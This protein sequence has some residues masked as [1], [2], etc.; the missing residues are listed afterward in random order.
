MTVN[1]TCAALAATST[2]P[3][4]SHRR[5]RVAVIVANGIT[6]DSRV[7]KTALAAARAGW[8]VTLIGRS[9]STMIERS[10]FGPV[11]V[12]RVP[13]SN[14]LAA[15]EAQR[16]VPRLQHGDVQF[17]A[18]EVRQARHDARS[19][20]RR[21][22]IAGL[23]T[24]AGTVPRT[25]LKAW[26]RLAEHGYTLG[27]RLR[28]AR[29][30]RETVPPGAP[31]GDWRR[32]MPMLL[33][34]D[35]AFGPV[36]ERLRPDLI[37]AND[38]TM[39]NTAASTAGVLRAAGH[40]V[41]WIYDA[42]EYVAGVDW[43]TRRMASGYPAVERELIHDADAV[44]TVSPEIAEVLAREHRLAV[45]PVV[46]RNT[47]VRSE[48]EDDAHPSVRSAAGV[49]AGV[50]LLVYSG[51]IHHERGIGV[52]VQALVDLP[53]HHLAVVAG[54]R[55]REL[56]HLLRTAES[57]GVIDRVHLAPYV[58]QHL[59]PRYLASADVGI[60]CSKRTIN[61]ELS[62]PTKFA[63]YVHAGLPVICSDVKTL[64]AW[65]RR[66]QVGEI[67]TADDPSSFADAVRRAWPRREQLSANIGQDLLTE[68]SW[69]HQA[70]ALTELYTAV[71]GVQPPPPEQPVSW[72]ARETLL[73]PPAPRGPRR[74]RKNW[75][76][77]GSSP[78]R[79]GLGPANFA[80]QMSAFAGAVC[81][82]R[83]DTTAEVFMYTSRK[84]GYPAD[85]RVRSQSLDRT[86]LQLEQVQRILPRYTHL[87]AD[88]FRPVFGPL[89]GTDIAGDLPALRQARISVGLV[90]HG[91]DVRHPQRH[92]E[93]VPDSL[94]RDAAP[95]TV[96][97]LTQ[98]AERH[99]QIVE[100]SGLPLFVTTPDLLLDV[101]QA[102]WAPLVVDTRWWSCD[103]PVLER[104]RPV[105]LHAPSRRWSKGTDRFLPTLEELDR[106]GLIELR[107]VED[108]KWRGMRA[109]VHDADIVVDQLVIGAYGAFAC[110]ALAA[111]KPVI[112]HLSPT[113]ADTIGEVPPIV[114]ATVDTLGTVLTELLDDRARTREIGQAGPGFVARHH[115]G[116][117]T[118][119]ALASFLETRA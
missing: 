17:T 76:P 9:T 111:G 44:V 115:D 83:D 10:R 97:Y 98:R 96:S 51:Y 13:V 90:A 49:A 66:H 18:D 77:L 19:R 31:V 32:D 41:R 85:V 106:R 72:E 108:L 53:E 1:L 23:D 70:G 81:A 52:A 84:F 71:T 15:L 110:E 69:E 89:N 60:I 95:G 26:N 105:V 114:N 24:P 78:V 39:L 55:N 103:R 7:Q 104:E 61:Y 86:A 25:A 47:P 22:L 73:P 38:I 118:A 33:D 87:L 12:I 45:P 37:H 3:P 36:I 50:P 119:A 43:P 80:G 4:L 113:L 116:R 101:P 112:T 91:T 30:A 68:L 21:T 64:S 92:L 59:V 93:R 20:Q 117:R 65:V 27:T 57:L 16:R 54:P 63:E 5:P 56:D 14:V 75:R 34:L 79:L 67:F 74:D 100:E 99:H 11:S 35:R 28:E 94:F 42:H 109:M 48:L 82:Q 6:G 29:E 8:E 88:A 46:V 102:T 40:P 58:P 62:L 2:E 107:L